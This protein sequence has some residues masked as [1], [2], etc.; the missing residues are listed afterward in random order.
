MGMA[1]N[2]PGHQCAP[3]AINDR[4]T[5]G[6]DQLRGNGLNQFAFDQD[7]G[8]FDTLLIDA[9]ENMDIGDQRLLGFAFIQN[10]RS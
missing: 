8:V 9:V 2:Q 6:I 10:N 7:A 3:A 1:V 4:C 5:L